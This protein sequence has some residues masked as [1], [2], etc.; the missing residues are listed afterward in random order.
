MSIN[1]YRF[2]NIMINIVN[3]VYK[4]NIKNCIEL[5]D[6]LDELYKD[7]LPITIG[8]YPDFTQSDPRYDMKDNYD[9]FVFKLDSNAD[10]NKFMIGDSGILFAL[11]SQK[12]IEACNFENAIVDWDCC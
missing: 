11:I 3:K 7:C 1:D 9:E 8:G 4:T 5:D 6:F 10:Y 2:L 12:D